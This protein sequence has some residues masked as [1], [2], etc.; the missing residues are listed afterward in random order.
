MRAHCVILA[1]CFA[2]AACTPAQT[3]ATPSGKPEV[4]FVSVPKARVRDA[5]V[6]ELIR[7]EYAVKSSSDYTLV[8]E[9]AGGL[10]QNLLAGTK[11][12]AQ[13][14]TRVTFTVLD[15]DG[16]V[17]VLGTIGVVSNPGS[18]FERT[19]DMTGGK[20]GN[21]IYEMLTSLKASL[22]KP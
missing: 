16:A 21:Q 15:S 13:T 7:R 12:D 4:D 9:R 2:L 17:K 14:M 3:Y 22:S 1:A 18:A 8:F 10:G 6:A 19:T 20:S 11:Y 5:L